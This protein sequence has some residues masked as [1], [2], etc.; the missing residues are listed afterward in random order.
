MHIG[1][2]QK[3][4]CLDL[5]ITRK[6]ET[7]NKIEIF[8]P[9]VALLRSFFQTL[10]DGCPLSP[11][12][13]QQ[14]PA[15]NTPAF[16]RRDQRFIFL[17]LRWR[18]CGQSPWC[19]LG[20]EGEGCGMWGKYKFLIHSNP[21]SAGRPC[22]Y[23]NVVW[24]C[25]T[26]LSGKFKDPLKISTNSGANSHGNISFSSCPSPNLSSSSPPGIRYSTP[27]SKFLLLP[28]LGEDCNSLSPWN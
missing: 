26:V 19:C 1:T 3:L 15:K 5:W 8:P 17:T 22:L 2:I 23:V 10:P 27:K 13:A 16:P 21:S 12:S 7:L 6:T 25:Y 24:M 20:A 4:L 11:D 14:L 28:G 9:K 18:G